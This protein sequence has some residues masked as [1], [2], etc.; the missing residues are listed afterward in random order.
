MGSRPDLLGEWISTQGYK[1][2]LGSGVTF[3]TLIVVVF[4]RVCPYVETMLIIHLII[5]FMCSVL[6]VNYILVQL[7]FKSTQCYLKAN[8]CQGISLKV[9]YGSVHRSQNVALLL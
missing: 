1:E 3:T 6:Y 7:L 9:S 8:A 4:S 5:H 2:T